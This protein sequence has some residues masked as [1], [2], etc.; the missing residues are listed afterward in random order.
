MK[1]LGT[2]HTLPRLHTQGCLWLQILF[3]WFR[4]VGVVRLDTLL[5][6]AV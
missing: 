1:C 2:L 4:R 6:V 3:L 5:S